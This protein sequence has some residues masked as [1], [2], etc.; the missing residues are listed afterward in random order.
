MVFAT[1]QYD[2]EI[3]ILEPLQCCRAGCVSLGQ[4]QPPGVQQA[5]QAGTLVVSR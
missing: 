5:G 2:S 4:P 3:C 1:H